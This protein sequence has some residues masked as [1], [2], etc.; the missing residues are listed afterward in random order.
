[1]ENQKKRCI[2]ESEKTSRNRESHDSRKAKI[3]KKIYEGKKK[4]KMKMKMTIHVI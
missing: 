4:K 2:L 1:M 3:T